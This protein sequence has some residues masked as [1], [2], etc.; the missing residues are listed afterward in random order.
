MTPTKNESLP[1]LVARWREAEQRAATDSTNAT[2]DRDGLAHEYER[3]VYKECADELEAALTR[4]APTDGVVGD[5]CDYVPGK[6]DKTAPVRVWLQIDTMGDNDD[7]DEEWPGSEHVTWQDESIGGLEIQYIRADLAATPPAP[8]RLAQGEL[9]CTD[10]DNCKRCSEGA[11]TPHAGIPRGTTQPPHHDRGE[12]ALV[13]VALRNL[14]QYIG[15]A[16]FASSVDKQAALNCVEVLAAALTEAKQQGPGELI[17]YVRERAIDEMR[18][19]VR[20]GNNHMHSGAL[21]ATPHDG[22]VPVY[23]APQVEAKR[24]TGEGISYWAVQMPGKMPKLYGAY[25]FAEL[26]WYPD[27][28]G[29]LVRLQEVERIAAAAKPSGEVSRG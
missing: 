2:E 19:G 29:D 23:L 9:K 7:R 4:E 20:Q 17:G 8:Q 26:N 24:Q 13:Q 15:K 25:A 18:E 16:S 3:Q 12:D 21:W 22:F 14:P 1:E 10:P 11:A 6:L 5:S 28:G 27:E